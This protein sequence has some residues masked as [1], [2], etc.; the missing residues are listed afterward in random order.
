MHA[1]A[2]RLRLERR[3]ALHALRRRR[4]LLGLVLQVEAVPRLVGEQSDELEQAA[5]A[6]LREP[7]DRGLTFS[8]AVEAVR[9]VLKAPP[10]ASSPAVQAVA[11]ELEGQ[12]RRL[13]L[14]EQ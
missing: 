13:D 8:S 10:S 14:R 4:P 12:R 1:C 5:Q 7:N 11:E 3:T 6:V 9:C 2:L